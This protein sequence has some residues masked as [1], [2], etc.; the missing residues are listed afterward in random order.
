[1]YF[2]EDNMAT[3]NQA[4]NDLISSKQ[5]LLQINRQEVQLQRNEDPLLRTDHQDSKLSKVTLDDE[6]AINN[7]D[8]GSKGES[9]LPANVDVTKNSF[10]NPCDENS[11]TQ[12]LH[13]S[14]RR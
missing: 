2:L 6:S 11:K 10:I 4:S 9:S 5:F 1:M 12:I 7:A 3:E 8:D 14:Q 13:H